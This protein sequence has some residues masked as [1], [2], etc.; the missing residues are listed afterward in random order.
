MNCCIKGPMH[1]SYEP[2]AVATA[3]GYPT[4]VHN[5]YQESQPKS[6]SFFGWLPG[7]GI[8]HKVIEKTKVSSRNTLLYVFLFYAVL[9]ICEMCNYV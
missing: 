4:N 7:S 9:I 8:M 3:G 1:G 5:T 6:D 2:A